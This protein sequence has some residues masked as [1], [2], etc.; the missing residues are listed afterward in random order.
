MVKCGGCR[1][2]CLKDQIML[3]PDLGDD[4]SRYE[5]EAHD[6]G[7]VWIAK[8]PN[9]TACRYLG[10][11]GCTIYPDRPYACQIF[12]CRVYAVQKMGR[13]N[14]AERRKFIKS[15]PIG[16]VFRTGWS[17]AKKELR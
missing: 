5:T 17:R 10:P 3:H 2:C 8:N 6:D 11:D 1:A 13:M 12:D 9:S 15:S 7:S 16:E 14:R 4:V